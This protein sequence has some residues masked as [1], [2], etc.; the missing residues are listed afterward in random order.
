MQFAYRGRDAKGGL[1]EGMLEAVSRDAAASELMRRGIVPLQV[2]VQVAKVDVLERLRDVPIFRKQVDLDDLI[3]YCR[4]M[5]ALTKAGISIIR[6]MRGLAETTRSPQLREVLDDVANR[7]EGGTAL[8]SAMQAHRTVFSDLFIAMIHVGENTGQ[9]DDA[10]ARLAKILELERDTR[11]RIKQAMRYPM[12]VVIALLAALIVVNVFV[13]P[14]FASVFAKLGADL[15]VLTKLLVATSDAMIN[16]WY[17]FVGVTGGALFLFLRWKKTAQGRPVWDR[18]KLRL[19]IMGKLL[20]QITLSR[21]ARN[22]STTL[23]A[24]MPVTSALTVVADAVD[25]AWVAQHVRDMRQ[26][27][28]RGDSLLRTA[29]ASGLFTPLILQMIAVGEETGG[30]DAMLLNVADFYD[31]EVDYGLKRLAE[32][33]EPILIVA[34]GVLVLILALGVFLPIWDLGRAAMGRG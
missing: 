2:E 26:G 10:F 17:L 22:F 23:S 4:Q 29:N 28:E 20:E 21:F 6:V 33:I 5:Y 34:M 16:Y 27:I 31:E 18:Y 7:L 32:S 12:F 8:A 1:Q 13:I 3:V 30:V 9:L 11:R 24:G 15:P 25:N 14:K 19:P